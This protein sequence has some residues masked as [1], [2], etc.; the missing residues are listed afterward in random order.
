MTQSVNF[1]VSLSVWAIVI[2][3]FFIRN[4]FLALFA[5]ALACE[6]AAE[7]MRLCMFADAIGIHSKLN[8]DSKTREL[9]YCLCE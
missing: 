7:V 3:E 1:C 9:D 5:I 8:E 2:P 4:N 6:I